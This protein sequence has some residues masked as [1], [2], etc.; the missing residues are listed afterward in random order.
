MNAVEVGTSIVKAKRR[1][2]VEGERVSAEDRRGDDL[3]H[4]GLADFLFS[5]LEL[6]S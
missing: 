4:H 2:V 5:S 1:D 3:F 6:S